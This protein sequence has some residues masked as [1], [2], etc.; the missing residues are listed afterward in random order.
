MPIL[1]VGLN[2]LIN[3]VCGVGILASLVLF[4]FN[5]MAEV[6]SEN[7]F[8]VP[9]SILLSSDMLCCEDTPTTNG[10]YQDYSCFSMDYTGTFSLYD[11]ECY[12]KLWDA[13]LCSNSS[14]KLITNTDPQLTCHDGVDCSYYVNNPLTTNDWAQTRETS[15]KIKV[16]EDPSDYMSSYDYICCITEE[17]C[18][19]HSWHDSAYPCEYAAGYS[20]SLQ[21]IC[22][23]TYQGYF[24]NP[25]SFGEDC[26]NTGE[27]CSY[28]FQQYFN[29]SDVRNL[30]NGTTCNS[31]GQITVPQSLSGAAHLILE[32]CYGSIADSPKA[33]TGSKQT[34]CL[35]QNQYLSGETKLTKKTDLQSVINTVNNPYCKPCPAVD[36][37]DDIEF[38]YQARGKNGITDCVAIMS[39]STQTTSDDTGE[40]E[41][42]MSGSCSYRP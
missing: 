15:S 36:G 7:D 5:A 37:Y 38:I 35:Q 12:D 1:N 22:N 13:G 14:Y 27:E 16:F 26:P 20:Y 33:V 25:G 6:Q 29:R 10:V 39:P 4:S 31:M 32:F 24:F 8:C 9:Q 3:R 21:S 17:A 11:S 30:A 28:M 41:V 18:C 19:L 2:S 42:S 34:T 40:Y 23:N